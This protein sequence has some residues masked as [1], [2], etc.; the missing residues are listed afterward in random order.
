MIILYGDRRI[1]LESIKEFR[2]TQKEIFNGSIN[3]KIEITYSGG[4]KEELHFCKDVEK[5][6]ELISTLEQ[7]M[8]PEET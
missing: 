3:Y 6:D 1:V 5:R 8:N 4:E 2:P 7:L